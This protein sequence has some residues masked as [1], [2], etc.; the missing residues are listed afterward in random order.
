MADLATTCDRS[1][2]GR[3]DDEILIAPNRTTRYSVNYAEVTGK[4]QEAKL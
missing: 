2:G 1:F 3:S 4:T